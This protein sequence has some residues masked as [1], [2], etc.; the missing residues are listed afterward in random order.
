[1]EQI[2]YEDLWLKSQVSAVGY[3]ATMKWSKTFRVCCSIHVCCC[4][5]SLL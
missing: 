1:M 3:M 2:L 4:T 5:F